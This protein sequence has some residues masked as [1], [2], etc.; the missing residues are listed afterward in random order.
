MKK[1]YS[2]IQEL[3]KDEEQ[4]KLRKSLIGTWKT[5]AKR[6]CVLLRNY[7]GNNLKKCEWKKLRIV[8]NYLTGSGFR[9]GIIK[10]KCIDKLLNE[11]RTELKN[12]GKQPPT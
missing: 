5:N 4:Q 1:Q 10:D 6:N 12:R 3:V 9:I 11:I 7:L 2:F 8:L